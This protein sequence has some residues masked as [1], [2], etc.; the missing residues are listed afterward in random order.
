MHYHALAQVYCR[1]LLSS[2]FLH[3]KRLLPLE[4]GWL[5]LTLS[6]ARLVHQV[7]SVNQYILS[8][9]VLAI[10]GHLS[11]GCSHSALQEGRPSTQR[12]IQLLWKCSELAGVYL[13]TDGYL[14]TR[15]L[16]SAF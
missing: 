10:H 1:I 3:E 13:Q 14:A 8:E 15:A 6:E 5:V 12:C 7:A 9:Q 4:S 16:L 2:R 11:S